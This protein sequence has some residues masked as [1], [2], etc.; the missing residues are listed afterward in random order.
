MKKAI[1]F[2][3][4][5]LTVISVTYSQN[6]ECIYCGE[7]RLGITSSAIGEGNEN[8]G[9]FSLTIGKGNLIGKNLQVVTL[10]GVDNIVNYNGLGNYSGAF[11]FQNIIRSDKSYAFGIQDTVSGTG[12]IAIGT[13]TAVSGNYSI[14]IGL[15]AKVAG[16]YSAVIGNRANAMAM[17]SYALGGYVGSES[18]GSITIG[19]GIYPLYLK[20]TTPYSLL[21]GF[22]S[23]LPTF[24]VSTSDGAGTT[25]KI[26]IGNI[27]SPEA[28]LH[29]K[30]DD[31]ENASILLQPTGDYYGNLMLGDHNH[32]IKAKTGDNMYF[33]TEN[34]KN[35]VFENGNVGIGTT[36]PAHPLQVNGNLMIS[37][38]AGSLLFEGD[39]K[40]EWG[41]WGIEYE[42]G[43]LNFWKPSGSNNFGN[44][45]LFLADDGNV[46]I[47]TED[48]A[49]KLEVNGNILQTSGFH[50]T[51]DQ[52]KAPASQVLS[53]T[54]QNGH[55]IFVEDGGNVSIGT[56]AQPAGLDVNGITKTT[57]FVMTT[58]CDDGHVLKSDE[59]GNA[60][61]TDPKTL[62]IWT[63]SGTNTFFNGNVGIGTTSPDYTLDVDGT[64]NATG[65]IGD[66]SNLT[67][68]GDNLG[69]HTAAQNI[70][71]N[72]NYL[73]GDGYDNGIFVE[74]SGNVGIGTESPSGLLSLYKNNDE[75]MGISFQNGESTKYWIGYNDEE[76]NR[77]FY[78]GG[79]GGPSAPSSGAIN[80]TSS[81][82]VGIGTAD[83]QSS[84]YKLTVA[85]HILA[86]EIKIQHPDQWYDYVFEDNYKLYELFIR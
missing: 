54:D 37:S 58:G 71:L 20:N 61:W 27:T 86:Q 49:A 74:S 5:M 68:V 43:G 53:L 50:I 35:F 32:Y 73:S 59:S 22:N 24:F 10:I 3:V 9:D 63:L 75:N 72:G 66:G 34:N 84:G 18:Q 79:T 65:F 15:N 83:I 14:G 23:D 55:G 25:G 51:S 85:G 67:G 11:G 69:N 26:G 12:S 82:N 76:D 30:A 81:G 16:N 62:G 8:L 28:K 6:I 78:F 19:I 21:V 48:P 56:I 80:V 70:K 46:G 38:Q 45:F 17:N 42:S 1:L 36:S 7:N 2:L 29:I 31:N 60:S 41:E 4:T 64:V 33:Q 40:G 39:D 57:G 13:G 44:Y 77:I 52:I 47:G